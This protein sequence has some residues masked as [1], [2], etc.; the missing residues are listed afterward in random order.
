MLFLVPA[1]VG[2]VLPPKAPCQT[3]SSHAPN[4]PPFFPTNSE[5]VSIRTP[6]HGTYRPSVFEMVKLRGFQHLRFKCYT[7]VRGKARVLDIAT[8]GVSVITYVTM[9]D[10]ERK[11][12]DIPL[13]AD[14]DKRELHIDNNFGS[15]TRLFIIHCARSL[16]RMNLFP[17]LHPFGHLH[18]MHA[19]AL[20]SGGGSRNGTVIGLSCMSGSVS[21]RLAEKPSVN[22]AT[23]S[24]SAEETH[25][26][27]CLGPLPV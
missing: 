13:C 7:A 16:I 21:K 25:L 18:V 6:F 15:P 19:R 8:R 22:S 5:N 4:S 9:W 20:P 12:V 2:L 23:E 11:K 10:E 26:G 17:F 1:L 3:P 24:V 14:G 27:V